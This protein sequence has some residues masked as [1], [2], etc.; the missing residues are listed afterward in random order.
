MGSMYLISHSL[1]QTAKRVQKQG[2]LAKQWKLQAFW[3]SVGADLISS[4]LFLILLFL[5]DTAITYTTVAC[6]TGPGILCLLLP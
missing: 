6:Q 4:C 1:I 2:M 3:L 5:F